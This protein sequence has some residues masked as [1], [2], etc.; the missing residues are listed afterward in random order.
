MLFFVSTLAVEWIEILL[1]LRP[2]PHPVQ[3][4]PSRWSGLKS[5]LVCGTCETCVVSTLAVEW[6]EI[7]SDMGSIH[8]LH[9][10]T[11]AVEWIEISESILIPGGLFRLHPRGGVD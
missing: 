11:L 1:Y 9:V 10:S 2:R 8:F 4:P 7:W 3:S 5:W 6:I